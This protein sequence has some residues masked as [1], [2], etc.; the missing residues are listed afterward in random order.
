VLSKA[1]LVNE[2]NFSPRLRRSLI[3]APR[4]NSTAK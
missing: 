1:V 2:F 3:Q 4:S